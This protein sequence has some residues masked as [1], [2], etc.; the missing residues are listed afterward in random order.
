[1]S[2]PTDPYDNPPGWTD[3]YADPAPPPTAPFQPARTGGQPPGSPLLTGLILGLLL[4][5]VSVAIF[6]LFG[7]GGDSSAAP[8]TTTTVPGATTSTSLDPDAPT[9]TTS[10]TSLP[11]TTPYPP[12][13]PAIPV[14]K[15]KMK[16]D[17]IRINDNDLADIDFGQDAPTAI[18]RLTASFGE[19]V[20]SGWQTSTGANGV[21]AGDLE[22][23]LTY[24]TFRAIVT[25]NGGQEIF[26]GYRNDI[27]FGD[28]S[29]DPAKMET[30][31]G[32]VIGDTV[33]T[34]KSTY[35]D[36][37][38]SFGS[39][40]KLGPTYEV[41]SAASGSVLLWGPV[42]GEDPDDQVIGIYAPD[43]CGR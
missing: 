8:E 6:Q 2:E 15:L 28:I 9:S 31:S 25:K 21:C 34:L 10:S 7:R 16:T 14:D 26:N 3:P 19:P 24:A 22:R 1:M 13:E 4:V 37:E 32:L 18:G 27:T 5:A 33:E 36:L 43:V 17:G 40:P 20:D 12:V 30:L 41:R 11:D 23:T 35:A 29:A 38:V 39:D 42:E